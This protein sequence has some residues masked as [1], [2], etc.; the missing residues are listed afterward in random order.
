MAKETTAGQ[1][2]SLAAWPPPPFTDDTTAAGNSPS[3]GQA[4]IA[5]PFLLSL[6]SKPRPYLPFLPLPLADD[7]TAAGNMWTVLQLKDW[8]GETFGD[9]SLWETLIQPA[10]KH[11][12]V[13][14]TKCAQVQAG[15]AGGT[16]AGGADSAVLGAARGALVNLAPYLLTPSLEWLRPV[17][18]A[19]DIF[20]GADARLLVTGFD[21]S[22]VDNLPTSPLLTPSL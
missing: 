19:P 2:S 22:H 4:L 9:P 10:M 17:S 20:S 15:G 13:C 16:E 18:G 3:N 5:T 1:A 12:V 8:L 6:P 21:L 14:T 11:I 7:I